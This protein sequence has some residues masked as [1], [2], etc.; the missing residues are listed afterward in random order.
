MQSAHHRAWNALKAQ[1]ELFLPPGSWTNYCRESPIIH[2]F[3]GLLVP[4]AF[5]CSFTLLPKVECPPSS[6]AVP[7]LPPL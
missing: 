4:Q 5:L 3:L 7:E 6:R 2:I 1:H